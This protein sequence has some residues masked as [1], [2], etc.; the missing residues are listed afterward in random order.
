MTG[1]LHPVPGDVQGELHA[2]PI[3]K[4]PKVT[5]LGI[6]LLSALLVGTGVTLY[7]AVKDS[8]KIGQCFTVTSH[9]TESSQGKLDAVDC[10]SPTSVFELAA[11]QRLKSPKCPEGDYL[12]I[13]DTSTR[14]SSSRTKSCYALVVREGDCFKSVR[15]I[16]DLTVERVACGSANEKVDKVVEG[17]TDTKLCAEPLMSKAYSQPARTVCLSK[18]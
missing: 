2:H 18:V 13:D 14:K 1:S 4:Q 10:G 9:R 12:E 5:K 3:G 7:F 6:I 8:V 17:K 11:E 15:Y 16:F